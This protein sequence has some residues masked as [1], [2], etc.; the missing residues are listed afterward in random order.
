MAITRSFI[1]INQMKREKGFCV[2]EYYPTY[3]CTVLTALAALRIG[4]STDVDFKV[5]ECFMCVLINC[6]EILLMT[7]LSRKIHSQRIKSLIFFAFNDFV[8]IAFFFRAHS[9]FVFRRNTLYSYDSTRSNSLG[10][11]NANTS[12]KHRR[13]DVSRSYCTTVV[14]TTV[15]AAAGGL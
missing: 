4:W 8:F 14:A 2:P 11:K 15:A 1:V 7:Y 5:T 12:N 6:V 13:V 3:Y 10:S 9:L